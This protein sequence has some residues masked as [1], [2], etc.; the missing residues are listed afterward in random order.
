MKLA[1][2][3]TASSTGAVRLDD[4]RLVD[5]GPDVGSHLGTPG[6]LTIAAQAAGT[7]YDLEGADFAPV[8]PHPSKVICVGQN[9]T[10]HIKEMGHE[11]PSH[12]TLFPKFSPTS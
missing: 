12:P 3:R 1:T 2:I 5:L 6:W 11:L 10:N 9:Y 8:V 7:T 4:D